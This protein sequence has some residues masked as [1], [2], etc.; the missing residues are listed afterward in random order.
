MALARNRKLLATAEG[1]SMAGRNHARVKF[2]SVEISRLVDYQ[3]RLWSQSSKTE[4]LRYGDQ[5]TKYFHC[6]ATE[7]N[8]K[9]FISGLENA[10]GE[11]MEGEEQIGEM[12]TRYYSNL[13]SMVNLTELDTVLSGVQPR[14]FEAM[15]TELLKPFR[16]EEVHIALKQMKPDTTPGLDG[17]PPL[18]YNNF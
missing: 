6:R 1:E 10:Q 17:L 18:F 5:N 7:R 4:W 14:V 15:S 11:W 2:L 12:L 13:F 9:N 8:K 16:M 3:E